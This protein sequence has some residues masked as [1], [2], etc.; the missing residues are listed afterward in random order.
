MNKNIL[1][2]ICL[3]L[4]SFTDWHYN[5]EDAKQIAKI[6]HKYILLNFSGSDWCGPCM[7]MRKEIFDSKVFKEMASSDLVLV[8]ADF[9]RK[10]KNQPTTEQQKINDELAD[11]YNSHGNFPYT[12]L[13]DSDGRIIKTWDGFPDETP[14]SFTLEVSNSIHQNR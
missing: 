13:L 9:P 7:R 14:Y 11:K 2:C 3:V 6:E 8:N 5:L 10:K 12:L 1:F 4:H